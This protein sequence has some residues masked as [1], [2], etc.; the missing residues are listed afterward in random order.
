MTTF[1][2]YQPSGDYVHDGPDNDY[3]TQTTT[4][5]AIKH[6]LELGHLSDDSMSEGE[7]DVPEIPEISMEEL[8]VVDQPDLVWTPTK[9]K[10]RQVAYFI[11]LLQSEERTIK[12]AAERAGINVD[13]AYKFNKQWKKSGGTVLPGYVEASKVKP[14]GNNRKLT[15]EH[16]RFLEDYVERNPTCVVK[17]A[18]DELCGEFKNLSID[19]STVYRHL[20]EKL[21]FTLTR[22]QPR[23][24]ERNSEDTLEQ[25][26]QFVQQITEQNIDF[27]RKCVFIDESGFVKNM[28]RPV[29]WSKK[30]TPA[31]VTVPTARG[32]NLSIIGCISYHGLIALS[33]QVPQS[34]GSKK[35]KLVDGRESGLPHGTKSSHFLLFVEQVAA[36]LNK[37]GLHNMYIVMDNA[38]IHKTKQ[39]LEAIKRHDHI[40]LFLPPYSPFLNPIEECWSK[41][42][43]QVRKTPLSSKDSLVVRIQ[44]AAKTITRKDCRGWIRHSQKYFVKCLDMQPI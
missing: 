29:A 10:P 21:S 24:M 41:M 6:L 39:V 1:Y 14:K 4:G 3:E 23:V 28:V 37:H 42:K 17:D 32:T 25:R 15:E 30:G 22:T 26:R 16:S 36:V 19:Q 11:A 12:R 8:G 5:A 40:P 44:E 27:R 38:S 2:H 34:T 35:R 13:A 7:E 9:Y 18:V 31:A 20:T 33:Q 43:G